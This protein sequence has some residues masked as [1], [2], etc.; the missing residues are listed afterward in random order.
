MSC[1]PIEFLRASKGIP[2]IKDFLS[3]NNL[4]AL[5]IGF[6]LPE[7]LYVLYHDFGFDHLVG[8]DIIESEEELI[9]EIKRKTGNNSLFASSL[10]EFYNQTILLDGSEIEG[11]E[12]KMTLDEYNRHFKIILGSMVQSLDP[13]EFKPFDFVILSNVLHLSPKCEF[14]FNHSMRFLRPGGLIYLKVHHPDHIEKHYTNFPVKKRPLKISD[15]TLEQWANRLEV[16]E[17]HQRISCKTA[18]SLTE[19][20]SKILIGIKL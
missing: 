11:R 1:H 15:A 4:S 8:I 7:Y 18:G 6:G 3:G 16:L 5:D 19:N 20:V 2:L 13:S 14:V 12:S 10:Y 17:M 9:S